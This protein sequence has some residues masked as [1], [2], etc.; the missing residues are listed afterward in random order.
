MAPVCGSFAHKLET[1][2]LNPKSNMKKGGIWGDKLQK[3]KGTRG[4]TSDRDIDLNSNKM[5]IIVT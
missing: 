5:H 4:P 3:E 1:Q 2:I